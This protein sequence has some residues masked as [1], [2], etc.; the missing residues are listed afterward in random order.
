MGPP[1]ALQR[2]G[3]AAVRALATSFGKAKAAEPRHLNPHA[4]TRSVTR[5]GLASNEKGHV[6]L[7]GLLRWFETKR[8][9][10][11][12][13]GTRWAQRTGGKP[14]RNGGSRRPASRTAGPPG[15]TR[16]LPNALPQSERM[17]D[18]QTG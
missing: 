1:W 14:R 5:P 15:R 16:A 13:R 6:A 18:Q 12:D 9:G 11:G 2:A 3:T 8:V 10:P 7:V 17:Y 4:T